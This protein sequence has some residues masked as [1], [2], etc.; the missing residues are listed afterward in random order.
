ML[1]GV[2]LLTVKQRTLSFTI[3]AVV[4]PRAAATNRVFSSRIF[5]STPDHSQAH[6]PVPIVLLAGFL[7]S[8][9]TSTLQSLLENA[10]GRKWGV[11]VNDMASVNV[12]GALISSHSNIPIQQLD[13]GCA[14]CSLAED[15]FV[16]V[17]ALLYSSK[18]P[19]DAILVELSGVGDPSA[20]RNNWQMAPPA[21]KAV[22]KIQQTITLVDSTTFGSDYWSWEETTERW[23]EEESGSSEGQKVAELLAE[24][25]EAADTVVLN[26]MD[27]LDDKGKEDR[28]A[29]HVVRSLNP[30]ATIYRASFGRIPGKVLLGEQ[31]Q[32]EDTSSDSHESTFTQSHSHEHSSHEATKEAT[33]H[34]HS[35]DHVTNSADCHDPE[36]TDTSHSHSHSHHDTSID[37][38]GLTSFVY[39]SSRPFDPTKLSQLLLQWPV[40]VKDTLDL[41]YLQQ[42]KSTDHV[43]ADGSQPATDTTFVGV[44]RSKGFCWLAPTQWQGASNSDAWRH[45]T[46]MY[47]SHAGKTFA[48]SAAGKWWGSLSD[49]QMRQYF[50]NNPAEY[51]RIQ[52]REFVSEE[53]GDRRQ[54][55][56]FIGVHLAKEKITQA[57]DACL[58][59]EDDMKEYRGWL[60]KLTS[61]QVA[62][63]Y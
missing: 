23:K 32:E 53:F 8:G 14:C 43:I 27:L 10:D 3:P 7:G 36:C 48:L 26:K 12:D 30:N 58:Y 22:A 52:E 49:E 59:S 62:S 44:L 19:L 6:S 17:D 2:S 55:I 41:D 37:Q 18:Q 16:S 21:V 1:L 61:E 50:T 33:S 29:E 35:H 31:L 45:D 42:Q 54:E 63:T 24:Q 57:L 46:A 20:V 28:V 39:R 38:L 4:R 9:K 34:S 5:S 15:L 25:V 56:V 51:Q 11:I 47:W 60:E 40:P 13:N